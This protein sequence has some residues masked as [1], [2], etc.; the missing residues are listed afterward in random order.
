MNR[1]LLAI[2]CLLSSICSFGQN[3]QCLQSGVKRYY[4]NDN[5]YLRG[6]TI[7]STR[8]YADS[9]IY[10]LFH[11]PRGRYDVVT[12][13][14]F[15]TLDP[16]G[17]SWLGKKVIARSNG[18]FIFDS[19]WGDSVIIESQ[20]HT[21]DSWIFYNDSGSLYYRA[22]L[23]AVDTMTVLA[24]LDSVKRITIRAYNGAGRLT[25]DPL[26]SF[27]IILSKNHGFVQVFDLYTFPYHEPDSVYRV[28]L[29]FFLD[30]STCTVSNINGFNGPAV[31]P[32]RAIT[33]FR[34]INFIN[35][36]EQQ[37]YNWQVGD[38][39][40]SVHAV[41]TVFPS[42]TY[43]YLTDTITSRSAPGAAV[44]LFIS[45]SNLSCPPMPGLCQMI[46]NGGPR[47]LY[48]NRY[49]IA[50]NG[51]MPE[52]KYGS[53]WTDN[54]V[55]YYPDDT[56]FCTHSPGYAVLGFDYN[57]WGL[58]YTLKR[59]YYKLGI[60]KTD[61]HYF[62]GEP[63]T[64]MDYIGFF[65]L[66]GIECG[67]PRGVPADPSGIKDVAIGGLQFQLYPNP[68]GEAVTIKANNNGMSFIQVSDAV[69]RVWLQQQTYSAITALNVSSLAQGIYYVTMTDAQ[70]NR[71]AEKLL[72]S[73]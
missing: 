52:S 26:D 14:S 56:T 35:P 60:G 10:Y 71:H 73:H 61:Y 22:T 18:T 55:F 68:A 9:T 2:F 5:H 62:V 24:T 47:T 20:A 11:T 57:P 1:T 4:L 46:C 12:P 59:A 53:V 51:F 23:T 36:N 16:N 40:E 19:Y 38:I 49:P 31:A 27:E 44:N 70:G 72:K 45:G 6:I 37:L 41:G 69:G 28:G 15:P 13:F 63:T 33:V 42:L 50:P 32:N 8:A 54:Y 67:T 17:G 3:Y 64:E 48:D 58:G 7:D 25:T 34:L 30:R 39:I 21:G 65:K 29:D 66:N 43:E